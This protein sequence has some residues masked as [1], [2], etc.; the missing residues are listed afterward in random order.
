MVAAILLIDSLVFDRG[1]V[2]AILAG[3]FGLGASLSYRRYKFFRP[4]A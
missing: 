4:A 3:T 1:W 2:L